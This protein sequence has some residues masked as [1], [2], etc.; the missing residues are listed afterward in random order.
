M[1]LDGQA[2]TQAL[3][4]LPKHFSLLKTTEASSSI[5][6]ASTGHNVTQAPQ[7]IHFSLS[8]SMSLG[9]LTVAPCLR[10]A[11]LRVHVRRDYVD[12]HLQL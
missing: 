7:L 1:A 5:V 8:T 3:H 2:S 12:G 10:I 6:I 9:M 11:A 4:V